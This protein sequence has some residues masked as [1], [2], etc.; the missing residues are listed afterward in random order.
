MAL[1]GTGAQ[2]TSRELTRGQWRPAGGFTGLADPQGD[3][4]GGEGG[5]R[6]VGREGETQ[7]PATE[8]PPRVASGH[9]QSS[10]R[11]LGKF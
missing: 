5:P 4:Q 11:A 7:L 2:T 8:R 6:R 1:G 9:G 3:L 10:L